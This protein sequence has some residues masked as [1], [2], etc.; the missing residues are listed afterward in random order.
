MANEEPFFTLVKATLSDLNQLSEMEKVCFPLDAWPLLERIGALTLPGV[1]RIKAVYLD[2]MIGFVGGDIRR[3]SGI[4]WISTI[5]VMPQ[6]RRMGVAEALLDT[7]EKEMGMPRV[8]LVVRKS[9]MSAQMLYLKH[10]YQRTET[11]SHYYQGGEDGIL[12]EKR[13]EPDF[14]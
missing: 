10:G 11:W 8:K 3:R 1:V 14:L 4:G 2:R 12:M 13:C 9:N 5:S 6:Y 7:C